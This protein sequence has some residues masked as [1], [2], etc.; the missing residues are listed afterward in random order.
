MALLLDSRRLKWVLV[1]LDVFKLRNQYILTLTSVDQ[2][3]LA[4]NVKPL[5]SHLIRDPPDFAPRSVSIFLYNAPSP[6]SFLTT[7]TNSS[8]AMN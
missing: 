3:H 7:L 8:T 5:C 2:S 6:S 1:E 4:L